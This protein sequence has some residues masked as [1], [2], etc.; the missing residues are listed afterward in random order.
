ML[1]ASVPAAPLWGEMV[2][3][4]LAIGLSPVHIALLLLVLLGPSPLRRGGWLV[5]AWLLTSALMVTALL[6][7]GHGLLLTMEK[8]TSHRTV[9]DLLAAG[10]LLGLGLR[11]LLLQR[12]GAEASAWGD[13]LDALCALPLVPLLAF[14]TLLQVVSPDD[15]FLYARSAGTLLAA[16]LGG[17]SELAVA[18]LFS[19]ASS[20]LL[21]L[22]L[23]ALLLGRE[24]VQP[25]FEAGRRWLIGNGDGLVGS[26]SLLL[27][28]YLGWQGIEGLLAG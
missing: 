20:L 16:G 6:T 26:I 13:R 12:I 17:A 11:E 19:L 5:A 3:F 8:G 27:A 25:A 21:L 23:L 10:V 18:A 24:R 4:A 2:G 14:S 7:L 28:A 15:L 22:P 9:L 1:L